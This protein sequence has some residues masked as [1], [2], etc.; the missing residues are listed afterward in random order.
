MYDDDQWDAISRRAEYDAMEKP[1][2]QV[3]IKEL[4]FVLAVIF[5]LLMIIL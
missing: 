5:V 2:K 1:T 4:V 3:F